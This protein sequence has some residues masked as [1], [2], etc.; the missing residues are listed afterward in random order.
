MELPKIE[1]AEMSFTTPRSQPPIFV[2]AISKYI[3]QQLHYPPN[4]HTS[5]S[6]SL[7]QHHLYPF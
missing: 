2:C 1:H 6:A 4:S 7:I 5:K 3:V